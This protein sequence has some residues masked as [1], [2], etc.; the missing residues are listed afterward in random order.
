MPDTNTGKWE[1]VRI[2]L[3]TRKYTPASCWL[4]RPKKK[5]GSA[6]FPEETQN[7][8]L[9]WMRKAPKCCR[10]DTAGLFW[11][12]KV[13]TNRALMAS[14][15]IRNKMTS[16]L[17]APRLQYA[18]KLTTS[19]KSCKQVNLPFVRTK[20]QPHPRGEGPQENFHLDL[21]N[22][23]YFQQLATKLYK[24]LS[25][26]CILRR[27]CFYALVDFFLQTQFSFLKRHSKSKPSDI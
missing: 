17:P 4:C 16:V 23:I 9:N 12:N 18:S 19:A 20:N 27:E 6:N 25:H 5:G 24:A 7:Q 1:K 21:K 8:I 13:L 3:Y 15:W 10:K 14:L 26:L 11:T 2:R 22:C